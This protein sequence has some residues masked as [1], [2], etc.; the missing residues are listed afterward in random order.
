MM[1]LKEWR[2]G[3]KMSRACIAEMISARI[4]RAV[5][6]ST[7][8]GWENGSLPPADAYVAIQKIT[9]GQVKVESFGIRKDA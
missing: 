9:G 3:V 5:A 2:K 8:Q 1:T 4:K 7:V 6:A